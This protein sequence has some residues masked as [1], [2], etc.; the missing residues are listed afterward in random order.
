MVDTFRMTR[1]PRMDEMAG[2]C[3]LSMMVDRN[4][5]RSSLTTVYRDKQTLDDSR[6]TVRGLR[7]EFARQTGMEVM[8]M[9][10][11]QL[12]IHH[13]RVPEMA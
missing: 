3:S 1:I 7:E 2:F 13:L 6:E 8:D 12:A 5:G 10:E 9:G 11:F 4:T